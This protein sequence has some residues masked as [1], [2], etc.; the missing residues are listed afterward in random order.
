MEAEELLN[1]AEV[2]SDLLNKI[3]EGATAEQKERAKAKIIFLMDE[4]NKLAK[5]Y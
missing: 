2:P 4:V 1:N 3:P 5:A